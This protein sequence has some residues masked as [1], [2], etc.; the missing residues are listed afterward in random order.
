[1]APD[2]IPTLLEQ[3]DELLA[4]PH[5][6][7]ESATLAHLER[8]LTDGYAYALALESERWRLEQRL[9]ELAGELHEGDQDEKSQELAQI[10]RRLSSNEDALESLRST[11][12]RLRSHATAVRGAAVG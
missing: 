4:E 6:E 3:I 7:G 5:S 2:A 10:S 11:L 1:V 9:S 12:A 8:T